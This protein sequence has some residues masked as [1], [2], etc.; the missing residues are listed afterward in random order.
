MPE[1]VLLIEKS[2]G[3]ATLTLNRPQAMKALSRQL[4]AAIVTAFRELREEQAATFG[5]GL[6]MEAEASRHRAGGLTTAAIAA[7]RADVQA[8][9]RAQSKGEG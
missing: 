3:A 1:T 2:E 7:R 4:R 5:D 6:G 8:R 9:G